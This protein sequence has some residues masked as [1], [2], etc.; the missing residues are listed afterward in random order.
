MRDEDMTGFEQIIPADPTFRRILEKVEIVARDTPNILVTRESGAGKE[1]MT[2]A[3]RK[4]SPMLSISPHSPLCE[5]HADISLLMWYFLQMY[6]IKFSTRPFRGVG[7][8]EG[9]L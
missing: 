1:P 6:I 8:R 5:R 3:I 4:A 7:T 2:R 9:H